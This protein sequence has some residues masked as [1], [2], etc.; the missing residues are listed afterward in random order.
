MPE[1]YTIVRIDSM[2]LEELMQL[3]SGVTVERI[4]ICDSDRDGPTPSISVLVKGMGEEVERGDCVKV[5]WP[6]LRKVVAFVWDDWPRVVKPEEI[7]DAAQAPKPIPT[8][9]APPTEP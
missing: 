4:W 2:V 5:E 6:I 3:P 8:S 9:Q 1:R 7:I